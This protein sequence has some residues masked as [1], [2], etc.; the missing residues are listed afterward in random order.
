MMIVK[1][2]AGRG[3]DDGEAHRGILNFRC[4]MHS[5]LIVRP[6]SPNFLDEHDGK[7]LRHFFPFLPPPLGG[8]LLP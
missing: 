3:G 8:A 1:L 2:G 7:L 6:R 5:R 4:A